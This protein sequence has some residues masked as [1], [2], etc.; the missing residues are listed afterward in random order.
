MLC[1]WAGS[2]RG[3]TEGSRTFLRGE[4]RDSAYAEYA[5]VPLETC[6]MLNEGRFVWRDGDMRLGIWRSFL[7]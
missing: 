5:K 3:F 6:G 1:S 7:D 4:W 2:T